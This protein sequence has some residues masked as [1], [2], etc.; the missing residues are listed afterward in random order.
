MVFEG[1]EFP[2]LW[3]ID[4]E[5]TGDEFPPFVFYLY[6]PD[7][8]VVLSHRIEGNQLPANSLVVGAIHEA[9]LEEAVEWWETHKETLIGYFGDKIWLGGDDES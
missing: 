4:V 5:Q 8:A 1:T 9:G 2:R 6:D 3:V 7:E